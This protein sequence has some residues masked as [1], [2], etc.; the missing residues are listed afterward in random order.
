MQTCI[1]TICSPLI[2]FYC[3]GSASLVDIVNLCQPMSSVLLLQHNITERTALRPRLLALSSS[4]NVRRHTIR[5][6]SNGSS[7]HAWDENHPPHRPTCSWSLSGLRSATRCNGAHLIQLL[8]KRCT[9]DS[10]RVYASDYVIYTYVQ[11][12]IVVR[13]TSTQ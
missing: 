13:S 7:F 12:K 6:D 5:F 3:R 10:A 8:N 9:A 4:S 11:R 1:V 2:A